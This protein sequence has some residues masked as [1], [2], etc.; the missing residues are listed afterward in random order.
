MT[1]YQ[2]DVSPIVGGR[3]LVPAWVPARGVMADV[4]EVNSFLSAKPV[5][6]QQLSSAG[7]PVQISDFYWN[8]IINDFSGG[9]FNPYWS[10]SGGDAGCMLFY[11]GGHS[12]TNFNG[13]VAFDF[14]TLQYSVVYLGTSGENMYP[15]NTTT[16]QYADGQPGA[17]HTYDIPVVI[18]PSAGYPLGALIIVAQMAAFSAESANSNSVFLFDFNNQAAGWQAKF[19]PATDVSW[20][21][22]GAAAWDSTNNRVYW[23][24][25][26]NQGWQHFHFNLET[27]TQVVQ[28]LAE[29]Y[30]RLQAI[31]DHQILGFDAERGV[32]IA[33]DVST[34]RLSRRLYWMDVN[35]ASTEKR[36]NAVTLSADFGDGLFGGLLMAKDTH[37]GVWCCISSTQQGFVHYMRP[38]TNLSDPWVFTKRPVSFSDGYN[39]D[40]S[41]GVTGKR[42]SY[43]PKLRSFVLKSLAAQ[44][45]RVYRP[46]IY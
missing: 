24:I 29:G 27:N 43:A 11:G 4:P 12:A 46:E 21:A 41:F 35:D 32:I 42:W 38:P 18:G 8:T 1:A 36:W 22:G 14:S 44:P 33:A 19:V 45:I 25:N 10:P 7:S 28:S 20:G 6:T 17:S 34:D 3:L 31:D 39:P 40:L 16:A 15:V 9:A 13:I 2:A 26:G 23:I 37:L 5:W 30:R